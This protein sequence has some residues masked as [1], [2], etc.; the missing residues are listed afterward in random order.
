MKQTLFF[1]F[2]FQRALRAKIWPFLAVVVS[3]NIGMEGSVYAAED[4]AR[5]DAAALSSQSGETS[6]NGNPTLGEIVNRAQGERDQGD[7]ITAPQGNETPTAASAAPSPQAFIQMDDQGKLTPSPFFEEMQDTLLRLNDLSYNLVKVGPEYLRRAD[8]EMEQLK[9]EGWR[10]VGF[11]GLEGRRNTYG[12]LSGLVCFHQEKNRVVVVYH[13]T[14]G[15]KD[16]WGTNF[17]GQKM[18]AYEIQKEFY[19]DLVEEVLAHIEAAKLGPLERRRLKGL[20][21]YIEKSLE[22]NSV[23]ERHRYESLVLTEAIEGHAR[24]KLLISSQK[25]K[26]ELGQA[27]D[28]AFFNKIELMKDVETLGIKIKG[29]VHKG[30]LKKYLSTKFSLLGLLKK[31]I[32]SKTQ[33]V[34]T[35]HS[36]AAALGELALADMVGNHLADLLLV[37]LDN[38]ESGMFA[39]YFLSGARTGDTVFKNWVHENV[40]QNQIAR[41]NVN[42]DP[43]T[44]ALGDK[45]IAEWLL[46]NVPAAGEA[47]QDLVGYDDVGRLLLDLPLE[48]WLRAYAQYELSDASLARFRTLDDAIRVLGKTI[49]EELPEFIQGKPNK[50]VGFFGSIKNF[51][52]GIWNTGS[53]INLVKKAAQGDAKAREELADLIKKRFAHLHYGFDYGFV[54][55]THVGAVFAPRIVGRDLKRMLEQGRLHEAQRLEEKNGSP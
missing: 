43:V 38:L 32:N 15:N 44:I 6:E 18:R 1:P 10:L 27:L 2:Q 26:P 50:V 53:M 47:L 28:D 16:G 4:V 54:N 21:D 51:F 12:D 55:K 52:S 37:G 8:E 36:Q 17:D 30:F 9:A 39:G 25:V 48:V 14:A 46:G 23:E 24:L 20:T 34:F 22:H 45:K 3:L 5:L 29:Q 13:G 35:G 7:G 19:K 41:Q 33:V 31:F 11:G 40:G 49:V 42:G